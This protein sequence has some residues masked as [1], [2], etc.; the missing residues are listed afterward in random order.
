MIDILN[1]VNTFDKVLIKITR[2]RDQL[3]HRWT[4]AELQRNRVNVNL[5]FGSGIVTEKPNKGRYS[6]FFFIYC[7]RMR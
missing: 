7:E 2:F 4:S 6:R 5:F 3:H 1:I